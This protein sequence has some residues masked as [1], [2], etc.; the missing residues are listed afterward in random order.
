NGFS[1][2]GPTTCSGGP[3]TS[4]S[5]FGLGSA[6]SSVNSNIVVANGTIRGMGFHGV[7]LFGGRER[8]E[9]VSVFSNGGSGIRVLGGSVVSC[10]ASN[11]GGHGVD[12]GSGIAIG[13]TAEFNGQF[14]INEPSGIAV[15]NTAN[16]NGG[17]G[18]NG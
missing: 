3:V 16:S 5:P 4:C 11:N 12:V 2:I 1:I 8:V 9:K 14:G 13:N 15:D 17:A 10:N 6:V 18:L 7:N